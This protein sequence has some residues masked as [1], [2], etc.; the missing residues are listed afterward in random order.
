MKLLFILLM[1]C[2]FLLNSVL[3][4]DA[5]EYRSAIQNTALHHVTYPSSLTT[6]EGATVRLAVFTT[7]TGYTLSDKVLGATIW[8]TVASDIQ[9]LCTDYAM[10]NHKKSRSEPLALWIAKLLGLPSEQAEKRFFVV[11]QVPVIQAYYGSTPS[12]IGIFRPCTDPRIGAHSYGTAIC[13]KQMNANDP[14]IASDFKTWFINTSIDAH[15]LDHGMPWTEYG[16]TYNWNEHASD[17]LGVSE[18]VVLKNTPV[19]VLANPNDATTPYISPEQYCG[20][21]Y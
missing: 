13:P 20:V 3:A 5:S 2:G 10:K 11:L 17:H 6:L 9:P 12:S 16:Y 18:F 1:L 19:T 8:A 15:T 4:D 7:Y 14:L 21:H